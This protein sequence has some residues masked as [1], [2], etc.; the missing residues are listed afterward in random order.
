MKKLLL[1]VVIGALITTFLFICYQPRPG[2]GPTKVIYKDKIISG[3]MSGQAQI[4]PKIDQ[5]GHEVALLV[6]PSTDFK[7]AVP[8]T[9][10]IE[11]K[12]VK[13]EFTGTTYVE[14]KEQ[15][16]TVKTVFNPD[17]KETIYQEPVKT[18]FWGPDIVTNFNGVYWGG[19]VQKN[20]ISYKGV[21]GFVRLE[22]DYDWRLKVGID[23]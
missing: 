10:M 5:E 1:G 11:T 17:A 4:K 2:P 15:L 22:K 23:F 6:N 3:N 8:V 9:G 13:I 7:T 20:F 21:S 18:L 12:K 16:L 19:H 14:R